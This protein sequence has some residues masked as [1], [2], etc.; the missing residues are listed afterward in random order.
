MKDAKKLGLELNQYKADNKELARDANQAVKEKE[1]AE[2]KAEDWKEKHAI[3]LDL[4]RRLTKSMKV[5]ETLWRLTCRYHDEYEER[6]RI[7]RGGECEYEKEIKAMSKFIK[8]DYAWVKQ[9]M[10]DLRSKVKPED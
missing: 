5:N 3:T 7:Y 9:A 4:R 10:V 1:K 8:K 6:V 2:E